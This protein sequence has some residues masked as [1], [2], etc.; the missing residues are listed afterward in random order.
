MK[1]LNPKE[2]DDLG[3]PRYFDCG[4]CLPCRKSVKRG[5]RPVLAVFRDALEALARDGHEAAKEAL[6]Y[7]ESRKETRSTP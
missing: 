1:C 6:K 7:E 4:E 3:P 5:W 2:S